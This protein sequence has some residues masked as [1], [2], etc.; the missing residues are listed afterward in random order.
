MSAKE[1]KQ[2]Q[3]RFGRFHS[4][5]DPTTVRLVP[6]RHKIPILVVPT[7]SEKAPKEAK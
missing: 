1:V 3:E 6:T 4:K 5:D 7:E 2:E